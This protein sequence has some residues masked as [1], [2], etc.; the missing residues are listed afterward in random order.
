M[1]AQIDPLCRLELSLRLGNK[2][3]LYS[4]E[5]FCLLK[6]STGC[7]IARASTAA[8]VWGSLGRI[9]LSVLA[10][11]AAFVCL[12]NLNPAFLPHTRSTQ[13]SLQH[14]S[15]QP[16]TKQKSKTILNIKQNNGRSDPNGSLI[17]IKIIFIKTCRHSLFFPGHSL[18][19]SR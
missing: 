13:S 1:Q 17:T 6:S 12:K 3:P 15:L 9:G 4:K 5:T 10:G 2:Y 19:F 8:L 7:S 14:H 18:A 11:N 16:N